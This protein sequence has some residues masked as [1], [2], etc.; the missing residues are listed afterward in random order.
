M[1]T[2]ESMGKKWAV[3]SSRASFFNWM[4][5]L[6]HNWKFEV[7]FRFF[8][9]FFL[10]FIGER[11]PGTVNLHQRNLPMHQFGIGNL[12][13]ES[14]ISLSLQKEHVIPCDGRGPYKH[15]SLS[16]SNTFGLLRMLAL[17]YAREKLNRKLKINVLVGRTKLPTSFA[18][19]TRQIEPQ[20]DGESAHSLRHGPYQAASNSSISVLHEGIPSTTHRFLFLFLSTVQQTFSPSQCSSYSSSELHPAENDLLEGMKKHVPRHIMPRIHN[21]EGHILVIGGSW[22]QLL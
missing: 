1:M 5:P 20:L 18:P 19:F 4:N 3:S 12:E 2:K 11:N 8:S 21:L 9:F 17:S 16:L 22:I 14:F 6:V 10:F 15:H 7:P 13:G